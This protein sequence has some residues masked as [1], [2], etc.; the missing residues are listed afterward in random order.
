MKLDKSF[1]TRP[2]VVQIARE[3]LAKWIFTK[4]DGVLTGGFIT[5]TEAYAGVIDR[6]SHAW[7][8]RRTVRTEIMYHEGGVAYIYFC[9]GVHSLF[10]IVTDQKDVP[11]AIL[12]R[13]FQPVVGI[14]E[15]LRRTGRTELTADLGFGPGKLSKA[16]GIHY[17][18]T[19]TSLT[20]NVIWLED[21][22]IK[23]RSKDIIAG[24]RIGVAYAGED[25]ALPYRF[26]LKPSKI[27]EILNR[28]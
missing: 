15:I 11:H 19:G 2:D 4:F 3:L 27:K 12:I 24:P 28:A 13:G 21:R 16:L 6:A 23:V 22:H 25:A 18:Q 1:Y 8:G 7:N 14:P 9:Y 17:T 5:E 20:G 26:M 10:N